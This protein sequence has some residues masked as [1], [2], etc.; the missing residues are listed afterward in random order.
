M[1][2][3]DPNLSGHAEARL[4]RLL[5]GWARE[6]GLSTARAED[7]RRAVLSAPDSDAAPGS[8]AVPVDLGPEWWLGLLDPL[9]AALS[10]TDAAALPNVGASFVRESEPAVPSGPRSILGAGGGGYRPYLRLV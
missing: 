4:D 7:L 2:D 9:V 8:A 6:R 1:T 5:A 3:G 10:R